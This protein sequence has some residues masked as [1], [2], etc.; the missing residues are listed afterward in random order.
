MA[1]GALKICNI[2]T[3]IAKTRCCNGNVA[4]TRDET[5]SMGQF[6]NGLGF[7][8]SKLEK[9]NKKKVKIGTWRSEE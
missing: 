6:F 3:R 4:F 7:K 9:N 5:F 2:L 1:S 8:N